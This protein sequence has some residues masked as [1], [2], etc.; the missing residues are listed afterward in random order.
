MTMSSIVIAE[1][2]DA[3]LSVLMGVLREAEY[4]PAR[5]ASLEAAVGMAGSGLDVLVIGPSFVGETALNVADSLRASCGGIVILVPDVLDTDLMR[6]ALRAGVHDVVPIDSSPAEIVETVEAALQVV[7]AARLET[8]GN[9]IPVVQPAEGDP[10]TVVTVFSTK[11][12]VGKTVIS[13]NLAVALSESGKRVVLLDLDL[14]FGDVGIMLGLEPEHT[15]YDAVQN[16]ERLDS[17]MIQGLLVPHP[18][19]VRALLA[20][21]HPEDAEAVTATRIS[22][23][24][25]LL[26]RIADYVVIDTSPGFNDVTLAALDET[27]I[28]YVVTMMDIASIKN[29]R[30]SIQKLAQ[31]GYRRGVLRL[32][33]NRAD[34]KVFLSVGDV[35]S[36]VGAQVISRIPSD[37][38]VPRSVNR[39]IPVVLDAP[40]SKVAKSLMALADDAAHMEESGE[41]HVA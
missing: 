34:S 13:T 37:L 7:K 9:V 18:S 22:G 29:T 30:I 31:L 11:G 32:V 24:I 36:A 23:I 35:E 26:R 25:A 3:I 8:L 4:A 19:G 40:R 5:A 41:V 17:A 38:V 1:S 6:R 12:G 33:L 20:P 15:V 2:D 27:D 14:Q 28:V 10:A 16:Y 39:G 21:V